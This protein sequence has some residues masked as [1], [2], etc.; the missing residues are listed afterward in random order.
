MFKNKFYVLLPLLSCWLWNMIIYNGSRLV[1]AG[2][3]H[4]DMT[5]PFDEAVPV[6]PAF[7]VIYFGCFAFWVVYYFMCASAGRAHCAKFVTFDL[8][9]RTVCGIL[10]LLVP[11]F[12][13]RP[14]LSGGNVFEWALGYL[15]QIDSA[16]N[17]F[18][19]IHCLVSWNCFVGL[20]GLSC[21]K[22]K[23]KMIAFTMA[24][25]VF[26]STLA[27]KQHVVADIFGAVLI[28]ELC[29]ALVNHTRIYLRVWHFFTGLNQKALVLLNAVKS[30][31]A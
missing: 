4:Y 10:F 28:S 23:H 5:T 9:S 31:L 6:V 30:R 8:L 16:D 12:N 3:V 19:S 26:I 25:L 15:Y 24:I 13:I 21:Y 27:T 11:T 7:I 14:E 17:L 22:R 1:N 20:R 2:R 18:P 29:W